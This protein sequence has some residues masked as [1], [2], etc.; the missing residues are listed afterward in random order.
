[1]FWVSSLKRMYIVEG[2][3]SHQNRYIPTSAADFQAWKNTLLTR[4]AA[5]DMTGREV[6]LSWLLEV[7]WKGKKPKTS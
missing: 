5:I 6:I 4:V 3:I 1:M 7:L 2:F